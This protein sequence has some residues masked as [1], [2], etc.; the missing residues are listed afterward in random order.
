MA[1]LVGGGND[2]TVSTGTGT[3]S[4]GNVANGGALSVSG[5]ATLTGTSYVASS[6]NFGGAVTLTGDTTLDTCGL[7]WQCD[8]GLAGRRRQ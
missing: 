5:A 1:S 3:T 6:E 7:A 4:L 2:L 8:L